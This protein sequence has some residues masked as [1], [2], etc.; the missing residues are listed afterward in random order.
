V[1]RPLRS[2]KIAREPEMM[3][4]S[5]RPL[6]AFA[7]LLSLLMHAAALFGLPSF[8][9]RESEEPDLPPPLQARLVEPPAPPVLK[10]R[11]APPKPAPRPKSKNVIP[12]PPQVAAAPDPQP[13]PAPAIETPS[14]VAPQAGTN[15]PA[16]PPEQPA[17]YPYNKVTM[18]YNL[19]WS[20]S[21]AHVGAV[22]HDWK[23]D[24][25]RYVLEERI[26]AVGLAAL[27]FGDDYVQRSEGSLGPEG[28]LPERYS[29][30]QSGKEPEGVDFNWSQT[31]LNMRRGARSTEAPLRI[32]TQD[33]LSLQHQLYFMRP[34]R[35]NN[36]IYVA[37]PRRL[38]THTI[39]VIGE[40][41]LDLP[42]G[43]I[44][45]LHVK[46]SDSEGGLLE[47]WLDRDRNL[48]PVKA[49]SVNRK[50]LVLTYKLESM[51]AE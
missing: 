2:R 47:L 23:L 31:R 38:Q 9:I 25:G 48:L 19:Y 8:E 16:P 40:E 27:F 14:S 35:A 43:V 49:Y 15:A 12:A 5:G 34:L 17:S 39:E 41:T 24:Q 51:S 20:E 46:S 13:A 45:T 44:R 10:K 33:L 26:E 18:R 30:S 6:F 32:G 37:T 50:G 21:E 7:L 29:F 3:R 11:R 22:H 28:L 42:P 1:P 36:I 4:V